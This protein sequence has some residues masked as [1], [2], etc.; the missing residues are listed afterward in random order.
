[1]FCKRG[2][3]PNRPGSV[4]GMGR[5]PSNVVPLIAT[6]R[7]SEN[8]KRTAA[9]DGSTPLRTRLFFALSRFRAFAIKGGVT[10]PPT[11]LQNRP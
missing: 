2:P 5:A 9:A 10:T 4:D 6:A 8:A 3:G 7:K 11:M 1:M